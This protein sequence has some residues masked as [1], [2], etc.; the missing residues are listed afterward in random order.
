MAFD[1]YRWGAGF[2]VAL[3]S[4]IQ[5]GN[6]LLPYNRRQ[7]GWARYNVGIKSPVLDDFPI[8]ENALS[9]KP[10]GDGHV[11]IQWTM[12][13][14]VLAIA[15]VEDTYFAGGTV[16]S[17]DMTIYTRRHV[18]SNTYV[19]RNAYM[20]LPSEVNGTIEYLRQGVARVTYRFW[21][22]TVAS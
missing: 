5:V 18:R 11:N 17:A 1:D 12:V 3:G 22:L 16:V 14:G 15:F 4:L 2:N 6:Q 8:R 21:N 19:R 10:R 20:E 9:G 13:L 7:S